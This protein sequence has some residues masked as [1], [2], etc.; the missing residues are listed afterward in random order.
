MARFQED[1]PREPGRQDYESANHYLVLGVDAKAGLAEI[2]GAYR[3]LAL[4]WHPD[5]NPGHE[6]MAERRFHRVREA[7][8][9]LSNPSRRQELDRSLRQTATDAAFACTTRR[10]SSG[11]STP[12]TV[13]GSAAS[14]RVSSPRSSTSKASTTPSSSSSFSEEYWARDNDFHAG[15]GQFGSASPGSTFG[16]TSPGPS[17][18][19]ASPGS[20]FSSRP[21]ERLFRPPPFEGFG[22]TGGACSKPVERGGSKEHCGLWRAPAG[23]SGPW[24]PEGSIFGVDANEGQGPFGRRGSYVRGG[25]GLEA[26][27]GILF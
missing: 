19:S 3:R 5:K 14:S 6:A 24:T 1:K 15:S 27:W 11:T 26:A 4:Q 20:S 9:V 22:P 13:N 7:F 2:K 10:C 25:V 21:S 17:F 12:T 18:G 8:E 23:C 16:S